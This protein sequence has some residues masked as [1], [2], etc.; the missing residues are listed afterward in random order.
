M[1]PIQKG[2]QGIGQ[3]LKGYKGEFH[4]G[5]GRIRRAAVKQHKLQSFRCKWSGI[6]DACQQG[7]QR[8][9]AQLQILIEGGERLVLGAAGHA[10]AAA[11]PASQLIPPIPCA[12]S[13]YKALH[14]G[15]VACPETL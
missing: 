3:P 7:G 11:E 1:F 8:L 4:S 6:R 12:A 9:H 15:A 14:V 13:L 10:S 2:D 5:D